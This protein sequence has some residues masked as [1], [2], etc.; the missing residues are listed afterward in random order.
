VFKW[1][2][3]PYPE[4]LQGLA[5]V[6]KKIAEA[7]ARQGLLGLMGMVPSLGGILGAEMRLER[8]IAFLRCVEA[9]RLYA[10]AHDGKLPVSLADINEVPLPPDPVTGKGFDYQVQGDKAILV[11]PELPGEKPNQATRWI[12]ELKLQR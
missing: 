7:K 11:R 10:A 3:L 1:Y 9:I 6:E 2:G 8:H 4:A 12:Y 5:S